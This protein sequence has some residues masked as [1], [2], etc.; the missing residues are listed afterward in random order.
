MF[1]LDYIDPF[2]FLVSLGIGIFV[3]YVI[4]REPR[5]IIKYPTPE[6]AGKITYVDD[7]GVCYR[8]K[9]TE[10]ECPKDKGKVKKIKIQT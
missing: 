1:V 6:N 4:R 8:Y 7:A 5:I 2:A 9:A 3:T 10:V